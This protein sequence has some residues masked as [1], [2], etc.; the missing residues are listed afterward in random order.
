MKET[1]LL[2]EHVMKQDRSVVELL[3]QLCDRSGGRGKAKCKLAPA[4]VG[5]VANVAN[6]CVGMIIQPVQKLLDTCHQRVSA[7]G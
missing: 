5:G 3:F 2:I 7:F 6:G 1:E 4:N